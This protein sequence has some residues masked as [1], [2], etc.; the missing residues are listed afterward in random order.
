MV[1][2]SCQCLSA[3]CLPFVFLYI[4]LRIAWWP[5][6][7]KELSSCLSA[8]AVFILC[9]LDCMR[10]FPIWCRGQDMEFDCNGSWSLPFHVLYGTVRICPNT[11][12]FFFFFFCIFQKVSFDLNY[13]PTLSL[14]M[15]FQ[16]NHLD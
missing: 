15:Y 4:L 1:Y 11:H 13:V 10:S 16:K 3:F 6:A 2:S 9:C 12:V 7:G 8:L 14:F 5:S